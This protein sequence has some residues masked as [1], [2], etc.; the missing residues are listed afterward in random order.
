MLCKLIVLC[1]ALFCG[2]INATSL[3]QSESYKA[4]TADKR[5][6][7]I[8]DTL[9][10]IVIESAQASAS[11]GASGQNEFGLSAQTGTDN[12][13]WQYGLGIGSNS[14][15]Q[16]ATQRQ[17]G[18]RT[19]LTV[20]VQR[21]DKNDNLYVK[22]KQVLVIDGEEQIIELT[23]IARRSDIASNNTLL[24][25]RLHDAKIKFSGKGSVTEDQQDGIITRLFK[26]LGIK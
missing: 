19:Q 25:N 16:A 13:G 10:I 7:H 1:L 12:F 26:W 20:S 18:I 2:G 21:V 5:A 8:G 22:G 9:T 4:L 17:G 6:L 11:A 14:E 23:G 3:Y 24:S 15:G